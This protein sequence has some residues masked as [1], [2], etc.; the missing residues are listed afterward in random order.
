MKK[1]ILMLMALG[2]SGLAVAQTPKNAL[3]GKKL[4]MSGASCAGLSLAKNGQD[5]YMYGEQGP[6]CRPDLALRAR[7]LDGNTL[8]LI[9][10]NR[11]NDVSPPRTFVYKIK[12]ISGNKAT[13]TEVWTGWG[14]YADSNTTYSIK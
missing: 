7:W 8:L 5:A 14:K 3:M 1:T 6:S 12:A 9:E 4:T 11:S 13:L 2:L 10:K